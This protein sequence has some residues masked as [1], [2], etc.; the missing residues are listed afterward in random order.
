[1]NFLQIDAR[2]ATERLELRP[3]TLSDA[4]AIFDSLASDDRV[5]KY[6][7]WRPAKR[8]DPPKAAERYAALADDMASRKRIAWVIRKRDEPSLCGKVELRV[9]DRDG[10][11]GY[12]L[13]ATRW[14]RRTPASTRHLRPAERRERPRF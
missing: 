6:I 11:V 5:P 10:E 9:K 12:V 1:M 14:R 4:Q 3:Q 2:I 7:D 13:A 8:W